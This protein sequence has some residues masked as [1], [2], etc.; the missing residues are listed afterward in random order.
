DPRK[1]G[2]SVEVMDAV[3]RY[4][5]GA[6]GAQAE[7]RA[8][9]G[10]HATADAAKL[11]SGRDTKVEAVVSRVQEAA[12]TV[13]EIRAARESDVPKAAPPGGALR[14]REP[15]PQAAPASVRKQH[16]DAMQVLQKH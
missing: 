6:S 7:R 14:P 12:D 5:E 4:N 11:T 3:L 9:V 13:A 10:L 16:D 15:A 2:A 1:E 8:F